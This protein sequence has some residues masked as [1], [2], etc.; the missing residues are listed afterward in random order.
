MSG[1][2]PLYPLDVVPI[3]PASSARAAPSRQAWPAARGVGYKIPVAEPT[4]RSPI[5]TARPRSQWDDLL[6]R[7][8]LRSGQVVLVVAALVVAGHAFDRLRLVVVPL[9]LG[10][11]LASAGWPLVRR[12]RVK[13]MGDIVSALVALLGLVAIIVTLGW[14]VV[15]GIGDEWRELRQGALDGLRQLRQWVG[16]VLP[17]A[18]SEVD[19]L[20]Q[21]LLGRAPVEQAREQATAGAVAVAEIGSGVILTLFITF[22][23]LKDGERFAR[24]LLRHAPD[25]QCDRI[26]RIG[27]R[28]IEVLG[29]F[30]RGTAI[31]AV[32]DA[33][34]IG[35]AL[36]L[37]G[38]P[39]ALPL[40]VVVFLGAFIPLV[41]ATAA[42]ALATLVALVANGPVTALI[43]VGVVIA[44]NQLEGDV[45]A[46]VVLGNAVSV[47]PLAILLALASGFILGGVVGALLA[48]PVVAVAWTAVTAWEDEGEAP[49]EQPEPAT[50]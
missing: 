42:G 43:V 27:S 10:V 2:M 50:S 25:D 5:A 28:S 16:D 47:H 26:E 35:L 22:F 1:T 38:V 46:P 15:A 33:V 14:I 4:D 41:G 21:G 17:G 29:A 23:L 34:A 48:V 32:V 31:V 24:K 36:V 3:R 20:R 45:L 9:L 13:G 39:L 18:V 7:L 6:G 40:A 37:L 19:D 11:I 12:M 8:A 44:V 49:Q 30:V